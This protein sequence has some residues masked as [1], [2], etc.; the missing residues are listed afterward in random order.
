MPSSVTVVV[1]SDHDRMIRLVR[2]LSRLGPSQAR[3]RE[4]LVL[5][6]RAHTAAERHE[7]VAVAHETPH[8]PITLPSGDAAV[9]EEL[10]ADV[11]RAPLLD[12]LP[13]LCRRVEQALIEHRETFRA[14]VLDALERNLSRKE[15]RRIGASY[16]SH[17]NSEMKRHGALAAPP[18]ALDRPR[19]ELYEMARR[20]DIQGRSSMTRTQLINALRRH[21][22]G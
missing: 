6:L 13:S 5:L 1:E 16:L 8:G 4:E 18:R 10:A 12:D 14:E 19:A 22:H 11:E 17:R 21:A 9:L 3:W 7:V 2:R 15:M 20:L